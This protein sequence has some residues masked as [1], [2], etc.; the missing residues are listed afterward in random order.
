MNDEAHK[1]VLRMVTLLVCKGD[2]QMFK[3]IAWFSL[4]SNFIKGSH[5]EVMIHQ[6]SGY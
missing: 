5:K 1:L 4:E 2:C 3:I 6:F